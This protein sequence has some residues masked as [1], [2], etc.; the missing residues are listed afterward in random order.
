MANKNYVNT[1]NFYIKNTI[2]SNLITND[3]FVLKNYLEIEKIYSS[4]NLNS[5]LNLYNF[6]F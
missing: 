6:I 4:T 5:N 1:I 2:S 3:I